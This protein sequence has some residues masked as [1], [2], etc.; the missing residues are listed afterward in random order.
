MSFL[1]SMEFIQYVLNLLPEVYCAYYITQFAIPG[2]VS[3]HGILTEII[4]E[5]SLSSAN[6]DKWTTE[7]QIRLV[8]TIL[9]GDH[10]HS[11]H[12]DESNHRSDK[13][14]KLHV[15]F[16]M[17]ELSKETGMV[18]KYLFNMPMKVMMGELCSS[19]FHSRANVW[20]MS[21]ARA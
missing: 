4:T 13:H 1:T 11:T 5:P 12:T 15:F 8:S 7:Q 20:E 6:V 17:Q 9:S 3:A 19:I 14:A 16:T 18:T 2:N 10:I 21:I